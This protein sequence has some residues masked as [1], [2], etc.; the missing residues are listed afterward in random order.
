MTTIALEEKSLVQIKK[1]WS[2]W[3]R[4][5]PGRLLALLRKIFQKLNSMEPNFELQEQLKEQ[6]RI[7][8]FNLIHK[9]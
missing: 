4:T 5:L 3:L 8:Y 1:P 7:N 6:H 2:Q 9:L